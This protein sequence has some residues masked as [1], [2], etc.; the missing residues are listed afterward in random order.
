MAW[1]KNP[2]ALCWPATL[3]N[4]GMTLDL[5][6]YTAQCIYETSRA[7]YFNLL[8]YQLTLL[9][10]PCLPHLWYLNKSAFQVIMEKTRMFHHKLLA[11]DFSKLKTVTTFSSTHILRGPVGLG[12]VIVYLTAFFCSFCLF[13]ITEKSVAEIFERL[14]AWLV[15]NVRTSL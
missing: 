10:L 8:F 7:I 3:D 6:T 4:Y 9:V 11:H 14:N 5:I 13:N 12:R 15:F 1:I 2:L